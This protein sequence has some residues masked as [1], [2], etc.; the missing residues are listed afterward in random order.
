MGL[1]SKLFAMQHNLLGVD[2]GRSAVKIVHVKP[3]RGGLKLIRAVIREYA[4][5]NEDG[6]TE[7]LGQSA[8]L[9]KN[10]FRNMR[11]AMNFL[12]R[13][14]IIRYMML[15]KMPKE[16]IREA[17][18]WEARKVIP[19]PVDDLVL[20]Y[21]VVGETE[22]KDGK[23]IELIIVGAERAAVWTQVNEAKKAGIR[24]EAMDVNPLCLMNT[25]RFN[26]AK[27]LEENLVFVDIGDSKTDVNIAKGGVLRFTRSV[28]LGGAD[29]TRAVADALHARPEEAERLK[30]DKGMTGGDHGENEA[31][32]VQAVK[33]EVDRIIVEVQRSIDYYRAQFREGS[34]R[35]IILMGGTP[36]MPGFVDYFATYFDAQTEMDDPFAEIDCEEAASPDI[37]L[38]A[39][40][41]AA[42]VGLALRKV[43]T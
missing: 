5:S 2:V 6:F 42:A 32:L 34:V 14:P 12:G 13:T 28:Q 33:G 16:E 21:L 39:P 24:I 38:M 7:T 36:L 15:P 27:Q 35:H 29:I 23:K 37:R 1:L 9:F 26:Y 25:V 17:V 31:P 18:K 4:P 20:D 19:V 40:R 10:G 43:G 41:F 3:H 8:A 30:R 11:T 22:D